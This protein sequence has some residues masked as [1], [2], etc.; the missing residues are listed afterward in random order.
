MSTAISC[1]RNNQ[2]KDNF[3]LSLI[4]YIN[5]NASILLVCLLPHFVSSQKVLS[6]HYCVFYDWKEIYISIE[7]AHRQL[8][9]RTEVQ[10]V[11]HSCHTTQ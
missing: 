3:I 1:G 5:F 11:K 10:Y 9:E 4:G 2:Q 6:S 8:E 7:V